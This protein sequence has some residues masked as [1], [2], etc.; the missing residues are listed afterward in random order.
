[1]SYR[2][3]RDK[4]KPTKTI[5][6]TVKINDSV[7]GGLRSLTVFYSVVVH[8]TNSYL[9]AMAF[10]VECLKHFCKCFV[11]DFQKMPLSISMWNIL[12]V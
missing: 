5:P 8:A 11:G 10:L 1:M 12:V 9:H 6:R 3:H 7:C 4:K 2:A